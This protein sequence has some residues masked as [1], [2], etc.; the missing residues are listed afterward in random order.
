MTKV[1]LDQSRR[2]EDGDACTDTGDGHDGVMEASHGLYI[3]MC[4]S[5]RID[6]CVE[7]GRKLFLVSEEGEEAVLVV[8]VWRLAEGRRGW[9][10]RQAGG[11]DDNVAPVCVVVDVG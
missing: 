3:S 5:F 7:R 1:L 9:R 11:P 10:A 8:G 6:V 2:E 4:R